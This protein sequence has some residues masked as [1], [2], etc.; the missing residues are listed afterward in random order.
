VT[1]VPL[2]RED[3]L[4]DIAALERAAARAR[5]IAVTNP[6]DVTGAVIPEWIL[7]EIVG[8][9]RRARAYLL[10]DELHRANHP[11]RSMPSVADLYERGISLAGAGKA[12]GLNALRFGWVVGPNDVIDEARWLGDQVGMGPGPVED[13]LGAIALEASD[14]LLAR[15][16]RIRAENRAV[17]A[18]WVAGERAV[19]WA[20]PQDGAVALLSCEA[21]AESER[22][23]QDLLAAT[24]V[25]LMPG[26]A[27]G[28]KGALRIGYGGDPATLRSGLALVSDFLAGR[29]GTMAA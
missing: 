9:A 12:F 2:G 10:A 14:A 11:A 28:R 21:A 13:R 6:C 5:V 20:G 27:L 24:G 4:P 26:A 7:G 15:A 18:N 3:G 1:E 19:T 29:S 8:I 25:L 23:C 22:F 16:S 17:L